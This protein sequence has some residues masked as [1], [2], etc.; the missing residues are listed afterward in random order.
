VRW[1]HRHAAWLAVALTCAPVPSVHAEPTTPTW[2]LGGQTAAGAV[3]AVAPRKPTTYLA[4]AAQVQASQPGQLRL[5]VVSCT[6]STCLTDDRTLPGTLI[7]DA[8]KARLTVTHPKLG[9]IALTGTIGP[10]TP[11]YQQ[12]HSEWGTSG[13]PLR[14]FDYD[15]VGVDHHTQWSG[16]IG[17]K[18]VLTGRAGGCGVYQSAGLLMAA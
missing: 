11:D 12:C 6:G 8:T 13:R 14:T 2:V 10:G 9:K 15:A 3:R 18:K 4:F 5:V 1:Q 7:A 16:K 17:T